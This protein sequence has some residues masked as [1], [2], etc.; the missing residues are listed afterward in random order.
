[1]ATVYSAPNITLL[2][3]FRCVLEGHGINCWVKNEFISAGT[4][5]IPPIECWP[6]LCVEERD[7][8][9]A[10]RVMAKALATDN[11]AAGA[12]KCGGCGEEIEGQFG[13]CWKCG[14]SAPRADR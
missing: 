11:P 8:A 4:G 9:E 10:Q 3:I 14:S 5:D 2:S 12:W 13:Q 7:L 1:M 6:Q